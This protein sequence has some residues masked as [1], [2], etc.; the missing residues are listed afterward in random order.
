M[1]LI[2]KI[3]RVIL[4]IVVAIFGLGGLGGL[5]GLMERKKHNSDDLNWKESLLCILF[6]SICC[7]G[8]LFLG[9]YISY[10]EVENNPS[11]EN[12]KF[13]IQDNSNSRY[14]D[15]VI[16]LYY[17]N[18]RKWKIDDL[19]EF[20]YYFEH[21]RIGKHAF[22]LVK[23]E[24]DSLYTLAEKENSIN[25]WRMYIKAVPQDYYNNAEDKLKQAIKVSWNNEDIA[26]EQATKGDSISGYNLYVEMYPRSANVKKATKRIIDLQVQKYFDKN[27]GRLPE[28]TKVKDERADF[29]T[30]SV[31]NSTTSTLILLCSGEKS[32]SLSIPSYNIRSLKLKNGNYHIVALFKKEGKKED[33][34]GIDAYVGE[35]K[36]TGGQY[37]ADYS[38]R[39]RHIYRT[40]RNGREIYRR[41]Y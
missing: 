31:F 16:N 9:D 23:Q 7:L 25:G 26:W 13:F 10:K 41:E 4:W 3:I 40:F 34:E 19:Y 29:S 8:A 22:A 39:T 28:M 2:L 24:C 15:D 14:Y 1:I 5:I 17:S 27:D 32:Y 33:I 20:A 6:S 18:A 30:I 21:T 12:C 36:F 11:M 38:I 35:Q 37:M